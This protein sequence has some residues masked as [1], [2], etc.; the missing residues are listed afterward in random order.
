MNDLNQL[1]RKLNGDSDP[2]FFDCIVAVTSCNDLYLIESDSPL[3]DMVFDGC[4]LENNLTNMNNVPKT[5]GI[6][7][8]KFRYHVYRSNHHEDPVEY[9]ANLTIESY[10]KIRIRNQKNK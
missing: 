9:D 1:I 6:Y 10:K 7:R 5:P 2:T 8:C 3:G 4:D